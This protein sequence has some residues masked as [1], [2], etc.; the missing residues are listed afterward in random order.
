MLEVRC[1]GSVLGRESCIAAPR[2]ELRMTR[3]RHVEGS[4]EIKGMG[5]H[6]SCHKV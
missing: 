6:C 2:Y 5:A 3:D 1:E 4:D